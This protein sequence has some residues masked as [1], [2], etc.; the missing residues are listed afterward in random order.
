VI[1][2]EIPLA[3]SVSWMNEHAD[4][5]RSMAQGSILVVEDD[6]AIRRGLVTVLKHSGYDVIESGHGREAIGLAL[7]TR[8]DLVMLD[9]M[10][11]GCDGFEILTQVRAA[12]P[13]LPI[14]MVTARGAEDDRVR[15]LLDG[16]DDYVVKPFSPREL[17]AR[18]NAVL[19]RSPERPDDVRRIVFDGMVVQLDRREVTFGNDAP[20]R[21][22][23]AREA[24]I[25]RYLAANSGRAV[26]RDEI[27]HRVWGLNPRG[28]TTRTVDMHIARL[29]EKLTDDATT[30]SLIVTV[31]GK[32]YMLAEPAEVEPC[33]PS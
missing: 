11:P 9:V 14:I 33:P 18:V 12:K 31:R 17:I 20:A 16:A 24:E 1:E 4:E 6:P 23:S 28:L 2:V 27:L 26:H 32:G 13:T 25:L 5:E 15:G 7:E 29:R 19:R 22:L 21:R 8:L 3:A 30:P 10:L